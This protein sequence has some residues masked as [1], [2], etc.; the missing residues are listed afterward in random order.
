MQQI[1]CKQCKYYDNEN[2]NCTTLDC[3]ILNCDDSLPC[4]TDEDCRKEQNEQ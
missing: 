4:E 1:E 2:I 3:N